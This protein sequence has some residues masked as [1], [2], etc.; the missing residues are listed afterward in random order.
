M[1]SKTAMTLDRVLSRYGLASRTTARDAILAG[2][3]RVNGRIVRDPEAW[4][5]PRRDPVRPQ[6]S[7]A[8]AQGLSA[9][10]QTQG[11]HH[12]PRRSGGPRDRLRAP[13]GSRALALSG[14]PSG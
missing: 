14:G 7:Q 13:G 4:V 9:L 12:Q 8:G 3:L 5:E 2:R 6:S 1:K 11:C 10:L